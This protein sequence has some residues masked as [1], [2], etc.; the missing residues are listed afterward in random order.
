MAPLAKL[1]FAI[2]K[3]V[4]ITGIT[5]DLNG[6]VRIVMAKRVHCNCCRSAGICFAKVVERVLG[7]LGEVDRVLGHG[8]NLRICIIPLGHSYYSKKPLKKQW[9]GCKDSVKKFVSSYW[10]TCQNFMYQTV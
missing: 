8:I 4:N 1:I 6:H 5:F 9:V 3:F 10:C 7:G 2:N